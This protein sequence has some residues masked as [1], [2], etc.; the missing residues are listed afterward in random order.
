LEV[1]EMK[2]LL[3]ES[4]TFA[5]LVAATMAFAVPATAAPKQPSC[6]DAATSLLASN[7]YNPA[8]LGKASGQSPSAING[9]IAAL[10]D[11]GT[12]VPQTTAQVL[13]DSAVPA[14]SIAMFLSTAFNLDPLHTASALRLVGF[15][16]SQI[17][18]AMMGAFAPKPL[19]VAQVLQTIGFSPTEIAT[20][21][22]DGCGL[23]ADATAA[24]LGSLGY[25]PALVA[26]V[27]KSVYGT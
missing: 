18:G 8:R 1:A 15:D 21:M 17:T 27:V 13:R 12:P 6:K 19:E 3:G 22:K 4:T 10:C 9:E 7:G 5:A 20:A 14:P 26:Q 16:A 11:S 2:R 23:P 25:T 24:I